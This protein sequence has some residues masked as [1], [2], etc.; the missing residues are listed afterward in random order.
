MVALPFL[1]G[2]PL[3]HRNINLELKLTQEPP[4]LLG[5]ALREGQGHRSWKSGEMEAGRGLQNPWVYVALGAGT[6]RAGLS[7]LRAAWTR[8][9]REEGPLCSP[10]K[11]CLKV[12]GSQEARACSLQSS[13]PLPAH[14]GT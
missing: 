12:E 3:S 7:L 4:H 6:P 11:A 13:R 5:R 1:H 9:K 14:Q 2:A 8:D 10:C